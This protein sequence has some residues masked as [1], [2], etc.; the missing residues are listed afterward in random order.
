MK[1][2]A[3]LFLTFVFLLSAAIGLVGCGTN[4][5]NKVQGIEILSYSMN[6]DLQSYSCSGIG[7]VT[8]KDIVIAS[9][10]NGLPVTSI[11]ERAFSGCG[12]LTSVAIPDSVTSIGE[13]AINRERDTQKT[14][15]I[16]Q[17]SLQMIV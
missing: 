6:S 17:K 16:T 15:K 5:S 2:T 14:S 11:G 10:Y 4:D 9:E 3:Y 1:I 13:C 12:G 8:Q 7:T